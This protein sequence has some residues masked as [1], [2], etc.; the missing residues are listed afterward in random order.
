MMIDR[1]VD[2]RKPGNQ[3]QVAG[4]SC[5]IPFRQDIRF[6]PTAD[7]WRIAYAVSGKGYPLVRA[8]IWMSHLDLDW[9]TD[10]LGALFTAL[11]AQ[12]RLYR[13]DP[14]GYGLSEGDGA[15]V[16]LDSLVADLEAMVAGAGLQRF[17]L[18]GPTSASS[19]TAT[20]SGKRPLSA[21]AAARLLRWVA[22]FGSALS[23]ASAS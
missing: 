15:D 5:L 13:Y 23:A 8:G 6:A 16:T 2:L 4:R 18:W 11:S 17:A 7:G 1:I 20:A 22:E 9:R 14:R 10:V 12:Y 19:V 21:K 3:R